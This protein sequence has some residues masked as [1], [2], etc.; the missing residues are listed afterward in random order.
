MSAKWYPTIE[1]YGTASVSVTGSNRISAYIIR[2]LHQSEQTDY[3]HEFP[4]P[5]RSY[6]RPKCVSRMRWKHLQSKSSSLMRSRQI[7]RNTFMRQPFVPSHK[8]CSWLY[9]HILPTCWL[10]GVFPF[11]IFFIP[12]SFLEC[13]SSQVSFLLSD[14]W[15]LS[16]VTGLSYCFLFVNAACYYPDGSVAK[17]YKFCNITSHGEHSACCDTPDCSQC[18]SSE[19]YCLDDACSK[20]GY[21]MGGASAMYRGGCTDP[22]WESDNRASE[23]R[24]CKWNMGLD[25][26][27][28][29][30]YLLPTYH[31]FEGSLGQFSNIYPC[32]D[33]E[34]AYTVEYCCSEG[35]GVQGASCCNTS[36]FSFANSGGAG[37]VY[38]LN[39]DCHP[40]Q[41]HRQLSWPNPAHR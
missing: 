25:M 36:N 32:S 17:R 26:C 35:A 39:G 8:L 15:S 30:L 13:V 14:V 6:R 16:L 11:G 5:S 21:C 31:L 38:S 34:G 33:L 18:D 22:S 12:I 1:G 7:I 10:R 28:D 24:T 23:C 29:I 19:G 41:S 37:N 3:H 9:N 40:H 4:H 2:H 20:K 27:E